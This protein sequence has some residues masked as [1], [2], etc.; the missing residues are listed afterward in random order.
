MWNRATVVGHLDADCFY[1]SA[2]RVRDAFLRDKA[3]GVLGNQG[4]CVIAKSYEMKAT[5]VGTGMPIW[6]ALGKC[7]A[8]VYLKRDFRWYELLSRRML[9]TVRDLSPRVE[10]YSIDEFFFA[11]RPPRGRTFEE[12]AVLIRD[13]IWERVGV[14][15]TVGIARTR[16][17]AKLISDAAKPFGARAVLDPE[18][19][20][21]LLAERAVT[22]ISGIAGR[23]A[24][25]LQPWGIRS[26]LDLARADRRLVRALLTAS[27]EALWWELNGDPVQLIRPQRPLPKALARGGSFGEST[28]D[29]IV[30][31]AWL[32]R[33]LERLIE[34]LEFHAVLA[35][36]LT[37][38]VA[39]KDGQVGVG[40]ATL[41]I[42][43]DRFDLLLDAARPCLRRAW[44]AR[45]PAARMH[46]I[47][48]RLTPRGQR[49]LGLFDPPAARAEAV[50]R[51]K[52]EVNARHGRFALR[53][54]ATLPLAAIYRDTANEYD[55]CDIRGK[56]C[57]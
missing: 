11:A 17:L 28:S 45:V 24:A 42:P 37:V 54:A 13:Q 6:E 14:P 52:R 30:L 9:D 55:I 33:N 4:A 18:A 15:V 41:A 19:E 26:C 44:V 46:L 51:L 20:A 31:Y 2:E 47:A 35:G 50:A 38:W 22:E 29:P 23:R 12:T 48:E 7:P 57:F 27:G 53:S 39:Y 49:P 36:R 5:G 56:I 25:R 16:T 3:V 43:T 8:G 21:K 10:Y 34:E 1:V 32:V 40:Q